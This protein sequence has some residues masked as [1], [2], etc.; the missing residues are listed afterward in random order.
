MSWKF[1]KPYR[2]DGI[3]RLNFPEGFGYPEIIQIFVSELTNYFG[4]WNHENSWKEK[5]MLFMSV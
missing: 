1:F 2:Q 5:V 4:I 3:S